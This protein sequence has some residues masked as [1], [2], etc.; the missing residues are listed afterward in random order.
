MKL[1]HYK[2]LFFDISST[3]HKSHPVA[4]LLICTI[5]NATHFPIFENLKAKCS[6]KCKS[7]QYQRLPNVATTW[8]GLCCSKV[9][10]YGAIQWINC[11]PLDKCY[12]NLLSYPFDSSM[13]FELC[14]GQNACVRKT[15]FKVST[16]YG[17][18]LVYLLKKLQLK[19]CSLHHC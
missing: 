8:L 15:M 1:S 9:G 12:Q 3:V 2:V 6:H 13:N 10:R 11:Y 14:R 17:L 16:E 7:Y 4:M 5:N 18:G 19:Y